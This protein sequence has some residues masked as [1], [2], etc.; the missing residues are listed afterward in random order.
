M[1]GNV[2]LKVRDTGI[3]IPEDKINFIFDRF[4]QVNSSL[5]RRAEGTGIG[6][7]LV[8]KLVEIMGGTIKVKSKVDKGS[9]FTIMFPKNI[10]EIKEEKRYTIIGENI[11]DKISTEFS[12]IV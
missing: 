3:G 9:E 2:Y 11:E 1:N 6:L 12:D 4:S 8:K 10:I 7:S 5:S